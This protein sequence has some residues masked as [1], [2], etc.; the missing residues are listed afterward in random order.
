[1][2]VGL[3][4]VLPGYFETIGARLERGRFFDARDARQGSDLIVLSASA[5]A[6]LLPGRD[7]IGASVQSASGRRFSVIGVVGDIRG[8]LD[9]PD[10]PAAY[11]LPFAGAR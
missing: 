8:R 10:I 3:D 9:A 6:T 5:A 7:P 1:M 4:Q 11:A 2:A